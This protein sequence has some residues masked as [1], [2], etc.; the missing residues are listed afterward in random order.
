MARSTGPV[1]EVIETVQR[2]DRLRLVRTAAASC[3]EAMKAE[4]RVEEDLAAGRFTRAVATAGAVLLRRGVGGVFAGYKQL[5][6][7]VCC[8]WG[9]AITWAFF[10]TCSVLGFSC[11]WL[12]DHRRPVR[13]VR[14]DAESTTHCTSA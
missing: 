12:D 11:G 8:L 6:F 9:E 14:F 7:F 2:R 10:S 1:L 3:V 4:G 13:G 5:A